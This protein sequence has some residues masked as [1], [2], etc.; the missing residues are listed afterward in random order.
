LAEDNLIKRE[1]FD[2]ARGGF[3]LKD[4]VLHGDEEGTFIPFSEVFCFD[5]TVGC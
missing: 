2:F 1:S 3:Y 4:V 5:F